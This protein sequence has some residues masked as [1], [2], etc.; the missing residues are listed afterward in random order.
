MLVIPRICCV[1]LT[2]K[3]SSLS[4]N[5]TLR[6]TQASSRSHEAFILEAASENALLWPLQPLKTVQKHK[7]FSQF[8]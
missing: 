2:F 7:P 1:L 3:R 4:V 5:W 8:F 6:P